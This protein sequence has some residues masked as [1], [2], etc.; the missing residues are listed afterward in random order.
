[1]TRTAVRRTGILPIGV[2]AIFLT[3]ASPAN[4]TDPGTVVTFPVG[5]LTADTRATFTVSGG[6][7]SVSVPTSTDLG[8]T[9]VPGSITAGLG[10]VTVTDYRS[11]LAPTWATTVSSTDFTTGTA[12]SLE[13]I[14]S[15]LVSYWSGVATGSPTTGFTFV[16]GQ[17]TT[18]D[19]VPLDTSPTAFALTASGVGGNSVAW[20]P[21]LVVTVP[22]E[23]LSGAYT[24]TVTHSVV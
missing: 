14:A 11:L 10:T 17:R 23:A 5:P 3:T 9:G 13:T 1:V 19:K 15:N 18:Q 16:A 2:L 20:S 6:P 21:T 24:G 22:A 8:A 4:A 12:T 7:L